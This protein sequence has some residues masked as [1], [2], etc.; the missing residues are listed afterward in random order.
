MATQEEHS[1][2]EEGTLR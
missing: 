2:S 1:C